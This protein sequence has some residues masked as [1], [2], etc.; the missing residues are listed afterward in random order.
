ML[1][2][3]TMAKSLEVYFLSSPSLLS[4][5]SFLLSLLEMTVH[6]ASPP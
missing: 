4:F 1:T 6:L 3:L 2:T 5:L